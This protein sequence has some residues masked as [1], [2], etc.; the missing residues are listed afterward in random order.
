MENFTAM[1]KNTL[2]IFVSFLLGVFVLWGCV[3]FAL[4][5]DNHW[6]NFRDMPQ[7]MNNQRWSMMHNNQNKPMMDHMNNT[8]NAMNMNDSQWNQPQMMSGKQNM[9]GI[10]V[11]Q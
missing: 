2:T 9:T 6:R 7:M 3:W 8:E 11:R 10:N 5:G 4:H 1:D